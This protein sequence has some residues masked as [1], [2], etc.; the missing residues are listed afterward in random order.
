MPHKP[1]KPLKKFAYGFADRVRRELDIEQRIKITI[2]SGRKQFISE[3]KKHGGKDPHSIIQLHY[4]A[5][6]ALLRKGN[7]QLILIPKKTVYVKEKYTHNGKVMVEIYAH[8]NLHKPAKKISSVERK[9]NIVHEI[10]EDYY[11]YNQCLSRKS[12]FVVE[13]IGDAFGFSYQLEFLIDSLK[14]N[15]GNMEVRRLFNELINRIK[16]CDEEF[17]NKVKWG[18]KIAGLIYKAA[19]LSREKRAEI[20]KAIMNKDF[21]ELSHVEYFIEK[22]YGKK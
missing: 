13:T 22:N 3:Y 1:M 17:Y 19:P 20:R 15:R 5:E 18:L 7:R 14:R 2:L 16:T 9:S 6:S 4:A 12:G 10:G 11:R 21:N 8:P